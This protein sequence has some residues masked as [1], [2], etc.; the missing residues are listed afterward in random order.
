MKLSCKHLFLAMMTG[1]ASAQVSQVATG[2]TPFGSFG[3]GPFDTVNLGNLN[4]HFAIPVLHK[5]GRGTP[6]TYD[7]SYDGSLWMPVTSSGTTQWQPVGNWGWRGQ[8]EASTGYVS[9]SATSSTICNGTGVQVVFSNWAYHDA[10]GAVHP[11]VG[12][13]DTR[14]GHCG[15]GGNSI[16]VTSADGSGWTLNATGGNGSVTSVGGRTVNPPVNMTS[17]S[18]SFTDN[19]GNQ[20]TANSTGQ[21]FDTLS[22]TTPV[23]TVA[24]SGTPTSP[25]TFQYAAPS[26]A[27]ATYTMHFQQYTV[28]TAFGVPGISEYGPL[29]NAL[30]SSVQLP[31]GLSYTF[32]YEQTPGSCTPLSGTFS[33]NCVT[34][35]IKEITL[36]TG[37]T[38][39]YTYTGGSNGIESDGSTAGLTRTL[40]PGGEW[41]Y[42]RA[43]VNST[44]PG[45]GS[46]WT[47]TVI[48][49]AG[50]NTV[51]HF[52]EDSTTTNPSSTPPTTATYNLYETQRQIYQGNIST[53]SCSSSTTNNC[54]LATTIRCYNANF[55][56]CS[57]ATVTSP[58]MQT[59][60][61]SQ[62]PNTN[63]RLSEVKYN[64]FGRITDDKEYDYGVNTGAAPN[65]KLVRETVTAYASLGNGIAN[66]PS[67]VTIS[68]WSSGAAVTLASTTYSYD[69][70]TPTATSGTPQHVAI[71][72]SRGLLT[73]VSSQVSGSGLSAKFLS[74][75]FTYYDTSTP[76]VAT[77]VNGAQTTYIYGTGSC[78]NSYP[79]QVN[80]PLSLSSSTT[81]NCT[82]GVA[83]QGQDANSQTVTTNYTDA[84]FWRPASVDDQ[85]NNQSNINYIGQ[86][87][88]ET[89]LSFNSGNSVSDSRTT[90]DGFGRPILSQRLQGPS[91]T[92]YDSTEVDYDNLGRP[93]RVTMAFSASAGTTNSTAPAKTM[94]YDALGRPTMNTDAG[95][96]TVSFSYT[97][98]DTLQTVGPAPVGE[99]AKQKQFEYDGLGRL[100]SVCEVTTLTGNGNCAQTTAKMGFWTQYTYDALGNLTKVLQNAQAAPGNQQTRTF[101]YD[102]VGRVTSETNPETGT[103]QY[104]YDSLSSDA[105]CGTV[106]LPGNLVKKI[107]AVGNSVC[108]SYDA[109]HRPTSVTYP[110]GSYSA[111]TASKHFVY[112][113]A[114]VN[115][116]VMSNTK[117]RMA[118]AYTCTGTC[119]SKIT[120]D[121]FSYSPRGETT[122]VYESTP[123]SGGYYHI[124]ASY[125]PTGA[126]YQLSG[127]PSVPTI[128]YGFTGTDGSGLDG[129]GRYT[130]V[131]AVTGPDPV[132]FNSVTYSTN[133]AT[134]PLG[135]LTNVAFGSG[136]SDGFT[137]DPNTGRMKTYTFSVNGQTDKG[138]L[139]WNQNGTLGKLVIADQLNAADNQTCSYMYDDLQ[140]VSAAACGAL[141]S[142]NFN[143][144]AFGNITK[145]VPTGDSGLT[146]APTYSALTNRF[147]SIPGIT[148]GY[149]ANGNLT[150]DNLN[151]YVWD[152]D[153]HPVTVSTGAAS[154]S[155]TYD[156]LGRMVEKNVSGTFTEFIY[157]PTGEKLAS[158]NGQTLIKAFIKLPGG[159]KA[160]YTPSGLAYYRHSDWL[161]TSRLA[162][163]QTRTL[164]SSSAYAPFGEQYATSGTADA[165]FTGQDQ[166]TVSNLYDFPARRYSPS[167]GRWI[168]PDPSG[169]AAV[170]LTNPQSW[171]RYVYV[172]NNPLHL[173][174]STGLDTSNC[175]QNQSED[176][177]NGDDDSSGGGS[178]GCDGG[179]GGGDD[180]SSNNGDD[181]SGNCD[182]TTDPTCGSTDPNNCDATCQAIQQAEQTAQN[183][184]NDPS[185]ASAVDGGTG[186]AT[187]T[188][189]AATGQGPQE[190]SL[191][192]IT[193]QDLGPSLGNGGISVETFPFLPDFTSIYSSQSSIVLNTNS[194]LGF[195][196]G[197]IPGYSVL[198]SQVEGILH[199]TGHA[200]YNNFLPSAVVPDGPGVAGSGQASLEMSLQNSETV[201][202]ACLPQ[203][204]FGGNQGPVDQGSTAV[205]AAVSGRR[206]GVHH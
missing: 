90:V 38:V 178:G 13:T 18:G 77:D 70:G 183:A 111:N 153:N 200:A 165:S 6:F 67:S 124:A 185:C 73:G 63:S 134:A 164:Y 48:D 189:N 2:R 145:S 103:T 203:G 65:T 16:T 89:T 55:A 19:N 197:A 139:T 150:M 108:Y 46:T 141:W 68:D 198:L 110:V 192:T 151:T 135:A 158:A 21:F 61:Y 169:R 193:T 107:D 69:Q 91:A 34:G 132:P 42:S 187:G 148:P 78:G 104:F 64:N 129:E 175:D 76:N 45:P 168:S 29:S 170:K 144:D 115:S 106:S 113:S 75:S 201:A 206:V 14:V 4:V 36:P 96:G 179:S 131:A 95:G 86:T 20:L 182:P 27:N 173:I 122:D 84:N 199:D 114:T 81:W 41:Q 171:N 159:A 31:D 100:T 149:D 120:D 202:N 174:D 74:K 116:V 8:T 40:N 44:A 190:F 118:E 43:Q 180:S 10:F 143:Y 83:I 71:T 101:V 49:P 98:N 147:L 80:G 205:A 30:V 62:I 23:L 12:T 194:T 127:I 181:N 160:V 157:S 52:A 28:K 204:D 25:V 37:G 5:A 112:D 130:R 51:I 15:N 97:N 105:A 102:M 94:T 72:G 152:A 50:N 140:R 92:N 7:L 85:E 146:F 47:T 195:I 54:L 167:Q 128:L 184:L 79:T 1:L 133:S 172:L 121:G 58:I 11:F 22:S 24:G 138:T 53:N 154:V 123:H 33:T 161:G 26:G 60:V 87:A 17:G 119:T 88:A 186:A 177:N 176:G 109:L 142:Q 9:R 188:L 32:T 56:S 66:R 136:D 155:V 196:N 39:T 125:H 82:G 126:L 57:T 137:Y 3:G 166:D 156:A 93:S 35:R 99:S 117:G 59:D 162:S 191:A 163:T